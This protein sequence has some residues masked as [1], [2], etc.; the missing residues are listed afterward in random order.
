MEP[1]DIAL[2]EALLASDAASEPRREGVPRHR[3]PTEGS[4]DDRRQELRRLWDEHQELERELEGL[5]DRRTLTPSEEAR[6]REIRKLKLAGRDR[7]EAILREV[8]EDV[9]GA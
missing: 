2:I 8:R 6:A 3:H 5:R 4:P 7:I 9:Q 1:R